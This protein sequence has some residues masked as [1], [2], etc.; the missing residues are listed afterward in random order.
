MSEHA[1]PEV[2][3]DTHWLLD[4][5]CGVPSLI[6]CDQISVLISIR[7][8]SKTCSHDQVFRRK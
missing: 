4:H 5:L 6:S 8:P 2:L 1:H 3:V 7:L